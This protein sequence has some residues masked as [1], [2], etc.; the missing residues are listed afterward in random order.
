MKIIFILA[1]FFIFASCQSIKE[2]TFSPPQ[3]QHHISKKEES[4]QKVKER[5]HEPYVSS[6][7]EIHQPDHPQVDKWIH[8]F[9]NRGRERME[10]YLNRSSRYI[11]MMKNVLREYQLPEDLVYVA[12]IE[13]G[14]SSRAHSFANAV[15]YWQF[16]EDTGRR[17]G[18][19]VNSYV[20]ERRDPVL[21]TRAAAEYFKDLYS[22]FE[23][24][25][26]ALASY[27]AGEYRVSRAVIQNYTRNFWHLTDKRAL[28]RE[29]AN[30]V[31]KFI[32]AL[33]IS[34][35]PKKYGFD[36]LEYQSPLEYDTVKLHFPISLKK[37]A[38]KLGVTY[39]EI[40]DLNPRY[41]GEYVPIEEETVVRIPIG[42]QPFTLSVLEQCRMNKPKFVYSN[43][44]W[45]RVRRGDTLYRLARRNRTTVSAIRRLNRMRSHTILRAGRKIKL[46]YYRGT[47]KRRRYTLAVDHTVKKGESLNSIARKYK[48]KVDKLKKMNNL[49][50]GSIIHPGQVL[51]LMNNQNR[52]PATDVGN[53]SKK[54]H[55][56]RRGDTLIGI[57]RKYNVSLP[58]LMKKNELNFKS[59]LIAGR[60][61]IIPE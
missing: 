17:Y 41:R 6:Y 39:K 27:N 46:P 58:L 47:K 22:A 30:Y 2:Q 14:F 20:D 44:Y 57:A 19:K 38:L 45:Y 31:P 8:Y 56:V 7:G 16:I 53:I 4:S 13:S 48:I 1:V 50:A 23:S 5:L 35:E 9:Q 33:R 43:H 10:T 25:H 12:M 24:W 37:M 61:I 40:Q 49:L 11:S 21:S 42:K 59:I 3:I 26:L 55:T 60:R 52:N 28:P 18:L 51:K 32:A 34:K 54:I 36:N 29:T 15:G